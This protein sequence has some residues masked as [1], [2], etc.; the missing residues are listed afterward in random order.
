M[1]LF[2][3]LQGPVVVGTNGGTGRAPITGSV[4]VNQGNAMAFV[5]AWDGVMYAFVPTTGKIV[6]KYLAT[7]ADTNTSAQIRA[8]PALSP[9]GSALYFPAGRA[10]YAVDAATGTL[11]WVHQTKQVVYTS[12]TVAADGTIV[13]GASGGGQASALSPAGQLLWTKNLS[14]VASTM[15]ASTTDG[16]VLVASGPTE[17][18]RN[19][20]YV[21]KVDPKTGQQLWSSPLDGPM[22][23]AAIIVD[24]A[25][26]AWT[27]QSHGVSMTT[28]AGNSTACTVSDGQ[29]NSLGAVTIPS[30]GLLLQ[31]TLH[32][33]LRLMG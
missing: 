4:V 23:A 18:C 31:L 15:G 8:T 21:T 29:W 13:Y 26:T 32:G 12:P 14:Y 24:A 1:P 7:D 30:E 27:A 2:V 6:W 20:A 22:Q 17:Q 33:M 3:S 28:I 11:Q 25:G 10:L 9:D 5:G 19:C 16:H